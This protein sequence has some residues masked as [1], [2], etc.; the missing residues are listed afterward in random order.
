MEKEI[1]MTSTF[2]KKINRLIKYCTTITESNKLRKIQIT[3][4]R[5]FIQKLLNENRITKEE[6]SEFIKNK[7]YNKNEQKNK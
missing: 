3:Q 2:Q 5:N 6:H 7:K 1:K 4:Y